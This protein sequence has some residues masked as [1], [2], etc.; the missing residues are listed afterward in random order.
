[1]REKL[2]TASSLAFV[3]ALGPR[4]FETISGEI[5]NAALV[6]VTEVRPHPSTGFSGLDAND[7]PQ[8]SQQS[9]GS[10]LVRLLV[11]LFGCCRSLTR[12]ETRMDA[13]FLSRRTIHRRLNPWGTA[14]TAF[15]PETHRAS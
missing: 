4:C 12:Q 6:G 8:P 5:V 9:G 11:R 15:G 2:L 3:A 10:C 7:A 14:A 1:M 13:L